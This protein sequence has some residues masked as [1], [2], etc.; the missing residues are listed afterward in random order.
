ML[1]DFGLS[2]RITLN[3]DAS[4]AKGISQRIG[5]G[6]MRH[7]EVSQLWLQGKMANGEIIVK[8]LKGADNIA[9]AMTKYLSG[10]D[11]DKMC[12]L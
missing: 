9:D 4:A 10:P 6:K 12:R 8:K 5:L 2:Y 3:L 11:A 7:L 1:S